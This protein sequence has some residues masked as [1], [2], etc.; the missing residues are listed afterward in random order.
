VE[1]IHSFVFYWTVPLMISPDAGNLGV[2]AAFVFAGLVVPVI[3]GVYFFYPE[4][5][6][7]IPAD[8]IHDI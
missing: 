1:L 6:G 5:S 2:R 3:I 4:V 8:G 7:N